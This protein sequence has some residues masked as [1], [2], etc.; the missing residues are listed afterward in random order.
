MKPKLLTYST[1]PVFNAIR[2]NPFRC[3]IIV[4]VV[5]GLCKLTSLAPPANSTAAFEGLLWRS[6]VRRVFEAGQAPTKILLFF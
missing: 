2:T 1:Y 4:Y 5:P 3:D 6:E